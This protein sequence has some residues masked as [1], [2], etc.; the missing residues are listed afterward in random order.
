M[1]GQWLPSNIGTILLLMKAQLVAVTGII[2]SR[3]HITSREQSEIPHFSGDQ[4]LILRPM[5]ER[6]TP[7]M[8]EGGGRANDRRTR[9]VQI[10]CR[11]RAYLDT[12]DSDQVRLTSPGLGLLAL[13]DSV[14]NAMEM[15]QVTDASNNTLTFPIFVEGPVA[16]EPDREDKNWLHSVF[17]LQVEYQ[18]ALSQ[19]WQ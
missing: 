17:T 10:V 4:D 8:L 14:R 6:P 19:S 5:Y 11:S 18:A 7:G 12:P 3:V 15:F 13:E 1:S 2:P 9:E 16:P